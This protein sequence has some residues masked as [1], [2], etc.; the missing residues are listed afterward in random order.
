MYDWWRDA[1][2]YTQSKWGSK[3]VDWCTTGA[4]LKITHKWRWTIAKQNWKIHIYACTDEQ[5]GLC[6]YLRSESCSRHFQYRIIVAW[7]CIYYTTTKLLC[8]LPHMSG[9]TCCRAVNVWISSVHFEL[10]VHI[11]FGPARVLF[12]VW[13]GE[14]DSDCYIEG[15]DLSRFQVL[16]FIK[17]VLGKIPTPV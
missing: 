13:I 5:R 10:Q 8:I 6:L 9:R 17:E 2:K 11:V 4:W 16:K 3:K 12:Y 7:S 1:L 15:S 14:L